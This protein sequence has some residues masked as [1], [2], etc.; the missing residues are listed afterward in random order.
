MDGLETL[1]AAIG[2]LTKAGYVESFRAR[3]GRLHGSPSGVVLEPGECK[4]DSVFRSEG[5]TDLDE[6]SAVFALSHAKSGIKGLYVVAY[7]PEMDTEDLAVVQA[8][9]S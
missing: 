1:S 2:R 4:I 3:D 8:L 7:G 5:I 6:E 9:K